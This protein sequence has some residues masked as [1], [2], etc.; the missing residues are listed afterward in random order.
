MKQ[1]RMKQDFLSELGGF[2]QRPQRLKAFAVVRKE[3]RTLKEADEEFR[4]RP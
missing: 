1:K 2:S 3:L 4:Y